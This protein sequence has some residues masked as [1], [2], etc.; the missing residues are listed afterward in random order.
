[1]HVASACAISF[2]PKSMAH[3]YGQPGI[4]FIPVIHIPPTRVCL[5]WTAANP[6]PLITAFAQCVNARYRPTNDPPRA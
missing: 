2:L 6:S 3:A 1:L 5:A 4:V